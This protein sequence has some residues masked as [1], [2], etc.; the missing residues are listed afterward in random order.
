M[1]CRPPV[2][3]ES[4]VRLLVPPASREHVMGDLSERY[5]S[6]RQYLM[7]AFHSLPLIIASQVRRTLNIGRI[8]VVAI[9]LFF[10]LNA[11]ARSSWLA[12]ALP[13]LL[14]TAGL[15]LRDA[16]RTPSSIPFAAT[17]PRLAAIDVGVAAG[18]VLL[19]QS[20]A[21]LLA[22]QWMLP[23]RALAVGIPI[24]GVLLFFIRL[25][26]PQVTSWPPASVRTMSINELM[27][28]MRGVEAAVTTCYSHR[29]RGGVRAR[30]LLPHFPI[31]H[32]AHIVGPGV[33]RG[34]R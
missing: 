11:N 14:A 33:Q 28:E 17:E 32:A 2:V 22:P 4:M 24:F 8:G 19:W 5:R 7:D 20:L 34:V 29:D 18:C 3:I 10:L 16:Y 23:A 21:D 30:R 12:A 26:A 25:E 1:H 31:D 6:P 9:T 27:A 13:T 15:I